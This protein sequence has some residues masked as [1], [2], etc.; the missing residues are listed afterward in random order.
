MSDQS[1]LDR[2]NGRF[3]GD[4]Y[5]FG[6]KP[7]AFLS[8]QRHLLAPG[9]RALALADG[10]GRNGVFLAGQDLKVTSVD[11]S[12]VALAKARRLAKSQGVAMSFVQADLATWEW[13]PDSFD[14]VAAI[15]IQFADPVLREAIFRGIRQTLAPGG[16]LIMQ[17]YRPEQI[18]YGTG[19]PP[20]AENMYT[21]A[22]LREAFP[23]FEILHLVEHDSVI[24]EGA[25]HH[26]LSALVDLVARK[27]D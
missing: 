1:S 8:D 27:P 11:F 13:K 17:G 26:G 4:D 16:L 9:Q 5:L 3:A 14:I 21:A 22:M 7:N 25:G 24:E 2:W 18:A 10:E 15:F 19:G 23:D 20:H 6:T 12:P